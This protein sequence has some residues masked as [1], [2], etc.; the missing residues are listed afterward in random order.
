MY[1]NEW[2]ILINNPT[3]IS[4]KGDN[5]LR[6][7]CTFKSNFD[8]E[9]Y[10]KLVWPPRHRSALCKFRCGVAPIRIETGRY[11]NLCLNQRICPFC[12]NEIESEIHVIL[13]C[14]MYSDLRFM[15]F[16]K[17]ESC[18]N[19]FANLCDNDKMSFLLSDQNMIRISA[20]TCFNILNRRSSFIQ[21]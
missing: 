6:T 20:K 18:S 5:K 13:H 4:K 1:V 9:E 10:C 12:T 15:L 14:P 3:G 17:A 8:V 16:E 11:N 19:N 7:Y 21:K 2:K